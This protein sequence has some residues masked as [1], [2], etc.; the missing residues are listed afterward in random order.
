MGVT[1]TY[2]TSHTFLRLD[3][4]GS[5]RQKRVSL[6][7]GREPMLFRIFG[8]LCTSSRLSQTPK[9]SGD[10]WSVF[11]EANHVSL[12]DQGLPSLSSLRMQIIS[13]VLATWKLLHTKLLNVC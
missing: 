8:L 12:I 5:H 4:S 2:S 6:S 13:S 9:R 10:G 1:S 3:T 7:S 11:T